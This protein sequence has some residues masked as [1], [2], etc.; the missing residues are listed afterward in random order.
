[1]Y[2]YVPPSCTSRLGLPVALSG[3]TA[4]PKPLTCHVQANLSSTSPA[5]SDAQVANAQAAPTYV[6]RGPYRVTQMA[7]FSIPLGQ[8]RSGPVNLKLEV[9]HNEGIV[10]LQ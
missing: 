2:L 5:L 1:M 10:T 9:Y 7:P 6:E 8:S 4:R 3:W